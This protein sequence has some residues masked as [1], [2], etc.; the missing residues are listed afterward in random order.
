[1]DR[2]YKKCG[3]CGHIGLDVNHVG[4]AHV[5]G[6]WDIEF[7]ICD[8]AEACIRRVK[9]NGYIRYATKGKSS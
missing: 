5:G 7:P 1:M 9:E 3:Y 4:R 8:D 2:H 6:K